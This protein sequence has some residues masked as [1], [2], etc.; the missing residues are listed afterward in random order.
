MIAMT[1][2]RTTSK[3]PRRT[4]PL[5][6]PRDIV[7]IWNEN[8]SAHGHIFQVMQVWP[9][10]WSRSRSDSRYRYLIVSEHGHRYINE[11]ELRAP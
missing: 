10:A 7:I 11:Q 8:D 9:R 1:T 6:H 3:R 4:P 5:F 2:S